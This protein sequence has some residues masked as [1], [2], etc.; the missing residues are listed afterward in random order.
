M[1]VL[2]IVFVKDGIVMSSDSRLTSTREINGEKVTKWIDRLPKTFLIQE[3]NVGISYC[4]NARINDKLFHDFVGEFVRDKVNREDNVYSI[5]KKIFDSEGRKGTICVVSGYIDGVP[6]VYCVGD[7]EITRMNVDGDG[8]V[9]YSKLTFG[10][11]GFVEEYY[12]NKVHGK[13]GFLTL[14]LVGS[15]K[16]AENL[17]AAAIEKTDSCGGCINTLVIR[18]DAAFWHQCHFDGGT[19]EVI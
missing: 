14:D 8:K 3:I 6:H 18:K 15:I 5:A 17:V 7:A 13:I 1:S 9:I 10:G 12:N 16:L 11:D 4:G 19:L 2:S